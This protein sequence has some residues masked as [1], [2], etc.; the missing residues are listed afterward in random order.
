LTCMLEICRLLRRAG[1]AAGIVVELD[2]GLRS[3]AV[4]CHG[5]VVDPGGPPARVL[6]AREARTWARPRFAEARSEW[7]L[8]GLVAAEIRAGRQRSNDDDS[9]HARLLDE[10]GFSWNHVVGGNAAPPVHRYVTGTPPF[11][12]PSAPATGVAPGTETEEN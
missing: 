11:T 12:Q 5:L 4:M 9:E 7:A 2:P 8:R 1:R 10:P 6:E 3:L